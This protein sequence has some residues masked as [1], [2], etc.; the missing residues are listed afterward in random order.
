[1]M[2][3]LYKLRSQRDKFI[4]LLDVLYEKYSIDEPELLKVLLDN[5]NSRISIN[6]P[7]DASVN[8]RV[9]CKES[10]CFLFL[11]KNDCL[12]NFV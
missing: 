5:A 8:M 2:T 11:M 6:I 10:G 1:M 3:T 7:S 4:S 12:E 9:K